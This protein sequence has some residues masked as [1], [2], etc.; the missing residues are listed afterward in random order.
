[1]VDGNALMLIWVYSVAG[2]W[3]GVMFILV[4]RPDSPT[5]LDIELMKWAFP[6]RS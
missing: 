4:R 5:R 2:Y 3:A 1:M 6:S